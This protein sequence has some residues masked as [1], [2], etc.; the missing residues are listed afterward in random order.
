MTLDINTNLKFLTEKQYWMYGP[1]FKVGFYFQK[2][3]CSPTDFEK[4]LLSDLIVYTPPQLSYPISIDKPGRCIL[5]TGNGEK[6]LGFIYFGRD[7]GDY[8]HYYIA[9]YP[10]QIEQHCGKFHWHG[11]ADDP[12]R[13]IHFYA[14]L[15]PFVRRL[16]SQL[17]F[18]LAF[19]HDEAAAWFTSPHASL[20]GILIYDWLAQQGDFGPSEFGEYCY[21]L[22][23]FD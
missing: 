14:E 17:N 23:P 6:P 2:K 13:V 16:H 22:L 20:T 11:N 3:R 4:A 10:L 15:I 8:D 18:H 19:I 7:R 21:A 12:Q 1:C 9:T 5:A